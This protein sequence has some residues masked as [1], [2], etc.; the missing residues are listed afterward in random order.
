ML[1]LV[2]KSEKGKL[3]LFLKAIIAIIDSIT[4]LLF[5]I[6]PGLIINEL[7]GDKKI[8]SLLTY[9]SILTIAPVVIHVFRTFI[10]REIEKL[11]MS[12]DINIYK[13][14]LEFYTNMDY[15]SVENPEIGIKQERTQATLMKTQTIVSN[16]SGLVQATFS[17]IAISSVIG[18]LNPLLIVMVV[19]VTIINSLI[20]KAINRKTHA[21]DVKI[22]EVNRYRESADFM[23]YSGERYAKETRIF[24]LQQF[25]INYFEQFAKSYNLLKLKKQTANSI[26][27]LCASALNSIQQITL[28]IYL[29]VRVLR[30]NL[31]IGNMTIYLGAV[32]Q[33]S[34]AIKGIFDSYL[35]LSNASLYIQETIEFLNIPLKQKNTGSLKPTFDNDS[36]IEFRDVSFKYPGSNTYAIRNMN[37]AFHSGEKLCIVGPNGSGKSTFIKLLARLYWPT[38]GQILLN[39][40]SIYEY[41]YEQYQQL[42]SPVFQDF[43]GYFMPLR[44]NIILNHPY[45]EKR[46]NDICRDSGLMNLVSKLPKGYDTQIGK[47][48][49]EDGIQPS[50]GE[51]QKIAIARAIYH[52]SSIYLLDEPTAALDPLIEHEIYKQF[53]K[54]IS[55]KTAILITHRLSAVQLADKIAVFNEGRL[56]EYGTHEEL[57]ANGGL[58]TDMFDK[59]AQFYRVKSNTSAN[60]TSKT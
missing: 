16:V 41:S 58:Y 50:G 54:M 30:F 47:W 1:G 24:G 37:L 48:I 35:N 21:I 28:Y 46:L 19:G 5:M 31:S 59:Q 20:T 25:L 42:F 14:F 26:P 53:N 32:T 6:V 13:S 56:M 3:F 36:F 29:F 44:E 49:D 15:E 27:G 33:L 60:T 39:G 2:W 9:L 43:S 8:L 38:E 40:K 11:S 18:T 34:S 52:N 57:Y 4:P 12:I 55:D 7:T 23:I 51:F 45:D 22:S 10:I 17:L